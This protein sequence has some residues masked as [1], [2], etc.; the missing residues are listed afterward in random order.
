M[1]EAIV[2]K[3]KK[4]E[5]PRFTGCFMFQSDI[6]VTV[7]LRKCLNKNYIHRTPRSQTHD[8]NVIFEMLLFY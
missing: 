5:F 7:P 8:T 6:Q 3:A 4:Y 1:E 2:K